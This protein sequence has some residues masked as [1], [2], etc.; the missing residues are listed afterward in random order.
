[1]VGPVRP[2]KGMCLSYGNFI[3]KTLK[4]VGFILEGEELIQNVTIIGEA[5]LG[6]THLQIFNG[7]YFK[8]LQEE[9]KV[10]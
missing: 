8:S 10:L 4:R 1:M 2:N 5:A 6:H 3:T 9:I 7:R